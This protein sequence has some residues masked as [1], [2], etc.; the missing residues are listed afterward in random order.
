MADSGIV[1]GV[2][3]E[4]IIRALWFILLPALGGFIGMA[5]GALTDRSDDP[6]HTIAPWIG[7][8]FAAIGVFVAGYIDAT[9]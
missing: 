6:D 1:G 9:R 8:F 2:S 4:L 5:I 7:L 3:T